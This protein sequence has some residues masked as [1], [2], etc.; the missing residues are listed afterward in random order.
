[1][2]FARL[3]DVGVWFGLHLI[4]WKKPVMLVEGEF[5]TARIFTL[6]FRNVVGSATSSVTE[7]QID[8]IQSDTIILGYD[9]DKA[10]QKA[11]QRIKDRVGGK[12][13]IRV[14]DWGIAD[15]H[16]GGALRS[17]DE[18]KKVMENLK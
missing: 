1:M 9:P 11:H 2:E 17:R 15:R 7:A 5:D 8:A 3:K 10:G 14:A 18:L 4:D 12:A 13:I 6:G 16:D